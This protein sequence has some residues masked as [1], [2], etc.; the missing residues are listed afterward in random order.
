LF[1]S[2]PW[3]SFP[4]TLKFEYPI[5]PQSKSGGYE[6]IQTGYAAASNSQSL[7]S[8]YAVEYKLSETE[9]VKIN[10]P[11]WIKDQADWW[12]NG[13]I[14][15]IEFLNS[16]QFLIREKI[17]VIPPTDFVEQGPRDIPDWVK[18]SV[19]WWSI[20]SISDS[21]LVSALQFLVQQGIIR[22]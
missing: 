15:D 16:I 2:N 1:L 12:V 4:I 21:E 22:V 3:G 6:A 14:S 17:I 10:I 19:R 11:P 5:S 13:A 20:G 18:K 9:S 8:N 7:V